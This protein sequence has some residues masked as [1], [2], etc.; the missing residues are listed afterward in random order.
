MTV[1]VG[2]FRSDLPEFADAT[3]YPDPAVTFWLGW[4]AKLI[5]LDRWGDV[6]DLG[7]EMFVAHNLVIERRN[8]D[9]EQRG[10]VPGGQSM[11]IAS[12]SVDKVSVS[13]D[14]GAGLNPGDG[15]WNLTNYGTRFIFMLKQ[16]G[17]GPLVIEGGSCSSGGAWSGPWQSQFPNPSG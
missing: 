1:S 5:N 8:L 6:F 9:A 14:A 10:G 13:Y 17:A 15:H 12:S 7:V 2:S 4:A 11:V 3:R 16:M